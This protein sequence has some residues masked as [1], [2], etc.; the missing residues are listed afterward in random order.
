[1]QLFMWWGPCKYGWY[2]HSAS[3]CLRKELS[4]LQSC[5]NKFGQALKVRSKCPGSEEVPGVWAG[6]SQQIMSI[7]VSPSSTRYRAMTQLYLEFRLPVP[8]PAKTPTWPVSTSGLFPSFS[9]QTLALHW[10]A[11][12]GIPVR[13]F[14]LGVVNN[15]PASQTISL[16]I[17]LLIVHCQSLKSI[18]DIIIFS[19]EKQ[20]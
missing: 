4:V 8:T 3:V 20:P 9:L 19:C 18:K 16:K 7:T 10:D 13:R 12:A 2:F 14:Y 6:N 15:P 11:G 17:I 1:M 5:D